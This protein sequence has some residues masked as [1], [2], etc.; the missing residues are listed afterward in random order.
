MAS[1]VNK[2]RHDIVLVFTMAI[3]AACGLVYEYL[4]AHFA[5]RI[6]GSVEPTIYAMIG[7]MIVAMGV[8]AF[9]AKWI[10]SIYQSFAWVELTIGLLGGI[11]ILVM[12]ASVAFVYLLP[13]WI[14]SPYG[15]ELSLAL[16]GGFIETL[17]LC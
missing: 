17:R 1:E 7:L 6:L 5:G 13:Q 4:M 16:A 8:G 9:S 3:L 15:I 12:S 14:Q 2:R 10:N 11:S